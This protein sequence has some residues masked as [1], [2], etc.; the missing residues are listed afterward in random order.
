MKTRMKDW[1][2]MGDINWETYGGKWYYPDPRK[3]L[4]W[5]VLNMWEATGDTSGAEFICEVNL[6]DLTVISP[7]DVSSALEYCGLG[8]ELLE[9]KPAERYS[10]MM[11]AVHDYG[12]KAPLA[13]ISG[14]RLDRVRAEARRYAEEAMSDDELLASRLNR[15]VNQIGS[16]AADFMSG[17]IDA[18]LRRAAEEISSG[19]REPTAVERVLFKIHTTCKGQ[20]LG[21]VTEE[22]VSMSQ[23]CATALECTE[24]LKGAK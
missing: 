3:A 12:I 14:K 20:T 23:A 21:G 9:L 15:Q 5:Y 22:S 7:R 17:A 10:T 13:S 1:E 19:A 4:C 16:T 18:G 2:F 11:L 8:D 6:V 24:A